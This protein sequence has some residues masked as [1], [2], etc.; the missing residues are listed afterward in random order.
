[1]EKTQLFSQSKSR[2]GVSSEKAY[3]IGGKPGG[4]NDRDA[5]GDKILRGV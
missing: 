5:E 4:E 2:P 3:P 1:M